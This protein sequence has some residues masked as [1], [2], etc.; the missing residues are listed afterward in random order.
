MERF[1]KAKETVREIQELSGAGTDEDFLGEQVFRPEGK[2][3]TVVIQ[4][5]EE[6]LRGRLL[7]IGELSRELMKEL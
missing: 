5:T 2:R 4:Q 3:Q 7:R 1:T 6:D